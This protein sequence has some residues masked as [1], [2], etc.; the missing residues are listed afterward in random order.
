MLTSRELLTAAVQGQY[1]LDREL[2]RGGMG[3]VY[4]A[5]DLTLGRQVALK[6]LPPL[7]SEHAETVARFRREAEIAAGLSHPNIVPIYGVGGYPDTP[8]IA[9]AYVEGESLADRLAREG[10]L[11][12]G[13]VFQIA[14]EVGSALVYA[15]RRE[16][17]HRDVKPSNVLLE[18]ESG[19][20]LLTDFGV[21]R[22]TGR[23]RITQSG[24]A[25][26]TPGYMA[27]EQ[28]SGAE[29]DARAD[30]YSFAL[31]LY[32]MLTG[33]R[34]DSDVGQW[35]SQPGDVGAAL[36][37]GRADVPARVVS[38]LSRALALRK[39]ERFP[40]L[41]D[42]LAALGL[43]TMP[44]PRRADRAAR[45]PLAW[46]ALAAGVAVLGI[47]GYLALRPS[48][49]PPPR[50]RVFEGGVALL[51]FAG[52][53][54][55]ADALL[56]IVRYQL[57]GFTAARVAD[58]RVFAP[59]VGA[60]P[61]AP[62]VRRIAERAG[63]S[64]I[65]HGLIASEGA[66]RVVQVRAVEARSGRAIDLGRFTVPSV[67]VAAA[68]SVVLLVLRSEVGAAAGLTSRRG[69]A[70]TSL[71]AVH[72]FAAAEDAF[73]RADYVR[74]IAQYDRVIALDPGFVLAR[75]RRFLA[76]LQQE[77]TEGVLREAIAG[78]RAVIPRVGETEQRLLG[79]YLLLFDSADVRHAEER[80][81]GLVAEDS[82]YLD[83]WFA[84]GEVRY[85]FGGLAGL[86]PDSAEAAFRRA[87]A[88]APDAAPALMHLIPL[89]FWSQ[90]DAEARE[91]MA[92]YLAID[93]LSPIARTILLART[94]AFGSLREQKGVLDRLGGLDGRVL[95]YGA[96]NG[97]TAMRNASD[98]QTALLAFEAL[99]DPSRPRPL[100][101][102]AANFEVAI[103][104]AQG[105]WS[106][107][108][109]RLAALERDLPED[110]ELR[111]WPGVARR[112]GFPVRGSAGP[113]GSPVSVDLAHAP[114][115]AFSTGWV[116]RYERGARALAAGDTAGAE[117]A[118]A[119]QDLVASVG[120]GVVRG[121]VWLAQG[122]IAI[123]RGDLGRAIFYLR[124][125]AGLLADAEPPFAAVRD[126]AR[127]ALARLGRA[128]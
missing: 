113:G 116:Q 126:S 82:T 73:R 21:A 24:M 60:D 88:L 65:L 13:V 30:Q 20:A 48:P 11:P 52:D 99:E 63:A 8:Y 124:R 117:A 94:A 38:A 81:R 92:R 61:E 69:P 31:L 120:D 29:V 58:P 112:L 123:A 66:A 59:R 67:G 127:Q 95:E 44:V 103:L 91:L 9:M 114:F 104:L 6:V 68:D 39:D 119:A 32:E 109:T 101:R 37:R 23:E 57:G 4:L 45:R 28:A 90:R 56:P 42:L 86:P 2:G 46:V 25:V 77:P 78:I 97:A 12:L 125:A 98:L 55:A 18:G 100:R 93:S 14:R 75:Y 74:A 64:W 96:I 70:A 50:P 22:S 53:S 72:A 80:L 5:R 87:L 27:P 102:L 85:H 83:G 110:G 122:R 121:P 19:R 108:T 35:P 128:F 40:E 71:E 79:A 51:A 1:A 115:G 62:D 15:H 43:A 106:D 36:R 41:A 84:L 26:G 10:A 47:A 7:T 111:R 107:A 76:A 16:I 34:V 17:V 105:R 3:L 49:G 89:A 118:F 54:A 33:R